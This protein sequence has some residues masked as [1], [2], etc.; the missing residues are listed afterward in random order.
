MISVNSAILE[1][2]I[3]TIDAKYLMCFV[4]NIELSDLPLKFDYNLSDAEYKKFTN[5]VKIRKTGTPIDIITG[6]KGFW[7]SDFQE[8]QQRYSGESLS[9]PKCLSVCSVFPE[10]LY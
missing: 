6:S 3:D 5:L 2:D 10:V 7:V 8:Q 1:S 9:L 4:L